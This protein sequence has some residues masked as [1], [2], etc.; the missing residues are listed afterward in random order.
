M[1]LC[2]LPLLSLTARAQTFKAPPLRPT[3]VP[4]DG[5]WQFHTGDN[6]A[7]ANPAFNDSTWQAIQPTQPWGSQGHL[8]YT[9]FAWY[10]KRIE[11]SP[12]TS[13]LGLY[14]PAADGAYEVYWN[15]KKIGALGSL[16]PHAVWYLGGKNAVFSLPSDDTTGVLALRFWVS[17]DANTDD[18]A[19]GG[20]EA[21]PQLGRLGALQQRLKLAKYTEEHVSLW[22]DITSYF[23]GAA[24]LLALLL[25][26]RERRQLLLL[27]LA[28]FLLL[29]A[30]L[31]PNLLRALE[32]TFVWQ[33][34]AGQIRGAM[35]V[36]LWLMLLSIFGLD[37]SWRW[38]LITAAVSAA[39]LLALLIDTVVNIFW[40]YAGP[41]MVRTDFLTTQIYTALGFYIVFLVG[42]GLARRRSWSLVPLG[43]AALLYGF[44][45]ML[46]NFVSFL[47]PAAATRLVLW[48]M[49]VG[50]YQFGPYT[51][52]N[53]V[54]V[55][56]ITATV[57]V[58]QIRE[59]RRQAR[60][61]MEIRS[62]QEVQQVLVPEE[63]PP[64]P[65]LAIASVYKP[66]SQVG[67]DFFQVI[68]L[69]APGQPSGAL[70]VVGDVS[71][72]GLKAAMLV[73]LIVGTIRTLAETTNKPSEILAGL[74]RRLLGRTRG[75]FATCLALCI[76]ADGHAALSNAGHLPPFR[77]GLELPVPPSLPLGLTSL[78]EY[79]DIE[80]R[81]HE[82]D[83]L[84]FITDGVL[85]ARNRK[86][87]LY[88]FDRVATLMAAHPGVH[89]VVDAAC[90][91]GQEDDITV[92]SVTRTPAPQPIPQ[93]A[94]AHLRP[95]FPPA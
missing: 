25:F 66:A 83:T 53:W 78:A 56:A 62:A 26:L 18:P 88:G 12:S 49:Q 32:P 95:A 38:R 61:A 54:I 71:G 41:G 21:P 91:F 90:D 85:E 15:G 72:K 24:G 36:A 60:I 51:I 70:I 69:D 80:L 6:L 43:V 52:T 48:T 50:E 74:N 57:I 5:A 13:P 42:F 75:G 8:G 27:W 64:I 29:D 22:L 3:S 59:G 33:V 30:F 39:Y 92:V 65:G 28:I 9:G 89:Q 37:R 40:Q 63:T 47:S 93:P 87:E 34:L 82:N 67:G 46:Q 79:E 58:Q 84:L 44:Y 76:E 31:G 10:R 45:Q 73:S 17:P 2:L 11:L 1:L 94:P 77:N 14:I 86:G 68:P 35:P 4:I 19:D 23:I 55:I 16:P 20:L 7:W 81:L